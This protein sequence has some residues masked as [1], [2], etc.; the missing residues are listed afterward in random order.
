MFPPSQETQ[1]LECLLGQDGQDA[2]LRSNIQII[3]VQEWEQRGILISF[4]TNCEMLKLWSELQM[5]DEGLDQEAGDKARNK[6]LKNC[7]S[8]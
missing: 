4:N 3:R 6:G 5:K 1:M 2:F 7:S 8:S